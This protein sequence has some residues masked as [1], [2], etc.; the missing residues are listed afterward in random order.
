MPTELIS[1]RRIEGITISKN[2]TTNTVKKAKKTLTHC[3]LVG[4]IFCPT[5][6]RE[7]PKIKYKMYNPIKI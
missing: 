7:G 4:L 3:S 1:L 5:F 2:T 6:F